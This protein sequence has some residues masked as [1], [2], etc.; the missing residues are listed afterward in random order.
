MGLRVVVHHWLFTAPH[1]ASDSRTS[2][3]LF[4]LK[5]SR[6]IWKFV[7]EKGI[8]SGNLA[9]TP[10]DQEAVQ[11]PYIAE[12]PKVRFDFKKHTAGPIEENIDSAIVFTAVCETLGVR[13]FFFQKWEFSMGGWP[14]GLLA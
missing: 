9:Q 12:D 11:R 13:K 10:D 14:A 7:R 3:K 2:D 5:H 6:M 8:R 4:S 1:I